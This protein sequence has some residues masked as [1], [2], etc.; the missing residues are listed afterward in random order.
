[1]LAS[2][3]HDRQSVCAAS[4][5][6]TASSTAIP[7]VNTPF[8]TIAAA[9]FTSR[10]GS[11]AIDDLPDLA[12]SSILPSSF[13]WSVRHVTFALPAC[14]ANFTNASKSHIFWVRTFEN[15]LS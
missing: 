15:T 5:P 11:L 13:S 2:P 8:R 10:R 12:A 9:R 4:L 3:W 6:G 7:A 14:Q 1:M